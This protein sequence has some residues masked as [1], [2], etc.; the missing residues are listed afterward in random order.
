MISTTKHTEE[1]KQLLKKYFGYDSF[2][3]NQAEIINSVLQNKDVLALMPT[4][5]GKSICFQIPALIKEG[6]T[7]VISP[8]IALMKDQVES[9]KAN[10][11]EA[12]FLNSSLSSLEEYDIVDKCKSGAIKLL[13]VSPEKLISSING[14]L[15]ELPISLF[16]VDEAHCISQ[17]GHDFRPEYTKMGMIRD[18]FPTIPFIALTATADKITRKD[19]ITQL[20]LN[21]PDVYISSFN[22]SNLSLSVRAGLKPENKLKEIVQ[23]IKSKPNESGIIYCLSRSGTEKLS[24]ALNAAGIKSSFY[25]AGMSNDDRSR[26]QE[27]F[28][29]DDLKI[30]CATIA[31]GMGIDKSNVRWVIHYNLP[32]AIEGYYQEIG[33][34]GRDGLASDTILFYNSADLQMLLRFA[35]DGKFADINIAK[36][37]RMQDYAEAKICRRRILLN[38]FSEEYTENCGNCDVC[39]NPPTYIDGKIIAQKILSGIIRTEEKVGNTMLINIL[40]GSQNKDLL[41]AGYDKLK[42][43]GVGKEFTYEEWSLYILQLLQLGIIE[44]AY[45]EGFLL[46]VTELGIRVLKSDEA[47]QLTKAVAREKVASRASATRGEKFAPLSV[48]EPSDIFEHLRQLRKELATRDNMPPYV[49]FSDKSLKEMESALPRTKEEMLDISGVGEI[50]FEKYGY[51]FLEKIISLVGPGKTKIEYEAISEELIIR[52]INELKNAEINPTLANISNVLIGK[53]GRNTEYQALS[54]NTFGVINP[55]DVDELRV[56]I[57]S[58]LGKLK[59]L[60]LNEAS[61]FFNEPIFNNYTEAEKEKLKRTVA[62]IPILRKTEEITADYILEQR[63]T[64]SRAFEPWSEEETNAFI[65]VIEYTNDLDFLCEVFQRNHNSMKGAFKKLGVR[66]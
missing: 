33:R 17:W 9:L 29:N 63:K 37:R 46:K 55:D 25:H 22:R 47:L 14:L 65:K 64:H 41:A 61:D 44:M 52:C 42:T 62:A 15:R 57:K 13:Y 20:Q 1:S 66:K 28:I 40:R 56:E 50:K 43:Y 54:L 35:Q 60:E 39:K 19:I 58:H 45:D 5:G 53:S 6:I 2:R 30:V 27:L 4:G 51:L 21:E 18:V 48:S 7:I 16:V 36:L 8:L 10:G 34:A 3:Q 38:Y 31:F 49:V 11:I 12:E 23:F 24:Q 59:Q 26:T 32:K